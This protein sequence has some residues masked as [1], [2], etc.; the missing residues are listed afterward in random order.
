MLKWAGGKRQLLPELRK[1]VTAAGDFG[2]YHE[3]F[4][5][6]GAL[7]FDLYRGGE[8]NGKRPV[9]SDTNTR[10]IE[11]YVS[12]RDNVEEVIALLTMHAARHAKEYYYQI[13]AAVP[14]EQT[15]R[16]AR[17]IYLNRTC[18]NGLYREN[19]KGFFNVP[20]GKYKN[21]RICNT[22]NL[23]EVS[24]ALKQCTVEARP[25]E[26]IVRTSKPGDLV[27]FDPPYHPISETSSFTAYHNGGFNAEDQRRLAEVVAA[28]TAKS[29]KVLLSNSTA[30]LILELYGAYNLDRVL[31]TRNVNSRADKRGKIEEVLMKNF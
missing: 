25:F 14:A 6:G 21:P 15:A 13:R 26:D 20:M 16:A 4:L 10:L 3:P 23:R 17:I 1:R 5:G 18:F 29:V 24:A 28:L 9:L 22:E 30:P 27:Y 8:L 2:R 31:A 19:S 11:A 7:F 12:V